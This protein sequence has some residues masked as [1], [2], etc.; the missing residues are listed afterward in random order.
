[1]TAIAHLPPARSGRLVV[2]RSAP[3]A[4]P[5]PMRAAPIA[6][7]RR[8]RAVALAA[9]TTVVLAFS[10][11]VHGVGGAAA[12]TVAPARVAVPAPAYV[13]QPGDTFWDIAR[14]IRPDADPRPLVARLMAAHGSPVLR[15]G[16][17]ILLPAA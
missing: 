11:A 5:Q 12:G 14:T 6:M 8:R 4:R 13:V 1:M 10:L 16:E 9:I 2:V 7:Y 17:R 15:A 3:V